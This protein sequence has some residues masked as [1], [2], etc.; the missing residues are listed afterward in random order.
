MKGTSM[1]NK[2][3]SKMTIEK[4]KEYEAEVAYSKFRFKDFIASPSPLFSPNFIYEAS[5]NLFNSAKEV[6]TVISILVKFMEEGSIDAAQIIKKLLD[7]EKL[8]KNAVLEC[9]YFLDHKGNAKL[10][11]DRIRINLKAFNHPSIPSEIIVQEAEMTGSDSFSY[12]AKSIMR[13]Q[14]EKYLNYA[15]EEILRTYQGDPTKFPKSWVWKTM[16]WHWM[17]EEGDVK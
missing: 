13:N 4:I 11:A 5:F 14:E 17:N 8:P 15:Y 3:F 7:L 2:V 16:K 1:K 12:Y 6:E 9:L 10:E